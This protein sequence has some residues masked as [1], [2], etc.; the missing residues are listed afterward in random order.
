[1]TE[2]EKCQRGL[3]YDTTV[4]GRDADH[5]RCA[6]LCYDYNH[7]RPSDMEARER[8]LRALFGTVGENPYVEPNLFCGFGWN[9]HMGDNFFANNNCVLVDPGRITFGNNV[10]IGPNCGFYTA[11][12]PIH[13]YWRNQL[14]E[15]ALP[16]TVGDDVW[17]GGHCAVMPGV[18]IGSDVVIGGG[19]VVVH[20]I[21]DHVVAVGNPCRVLRP[22]T[23]AD[24][25]SQR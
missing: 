12:H 18:T 10:F 20:D 9:I 22:I 19:S 16:I 21:P 11:N 17:F 25:I 6:D 23:E 2:F 8:I 1:M 7:T 13:A 5:L 15:Y 24:K 14:Y 4:T 3:L